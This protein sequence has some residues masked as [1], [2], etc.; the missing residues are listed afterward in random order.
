MELLIKKIKT[1]TEELS[2]ADPRN[3]AYIK[4][5]NTDIKINF[6]EFLIFYADWLLDPQSQEKIKEMIYLEIT[7]TIPSFINAD[8]E[9]IEKLKFSL[10]CQ[11]DEEFKKIFQ[12]LLPNTETIANNID[13]KIKEI[14]LN[15][16]IDRIA[17]EKEEWK[18]EVCSL[19]QNNN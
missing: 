4:V 3:K 11:D 14:C 15:E 17:K 8:E 7:K 16:I 13:R 6:Y 19:Y 1:I 10:D 18:R 5:E 9:E 12:P 2:Y